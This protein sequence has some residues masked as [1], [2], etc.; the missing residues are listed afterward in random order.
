[1]PL[2]QCTVRD[3][4]S[5]GGSPVYVCLFRLR[6]SADSPT[7][8]AVLLGVIAPS[9]GLRR[10]YIQ[11]ISLHGLVRSQNIEMG[12]DADTGGQ[13]RYVIELAK[14]L[15]ATPG[16]TRVDLFTR[17]IRDKRISPDYSEEIEFISEN[18]QIVRLSCGGG[19]YHRKEKIWPFVDEYVDRMLSYTRKLGL[20]PAVVHGHYADAGYIAKEMASALG[21]PF[22]FTGHSLGKPK[23]DYLLEE[24]WTREKC[25][26]VLAID[27]RIHVE[28]ECLAAADLVIC[29]T[30]H[31]KDTGYCKYPRNEKCR[32][33]VIPPGTDLNRF[34]PYY[35]YQ[36][37]PLGISEKFKQARVHME[38][39]LQQFLF[40]PEKPV[41]V[42]LCRPD[43]RKNIQAL[44]KAYGESLPLQ[45]IS[46]LVILAGI[47]RDIEVMPDNEREVL[48]DILLM[49]DRYNLYGKMAIPKEHDSEF[50]VPELYRIAA[51]GHG[52]FA[53]TA[54]V[55]LFGLTF[56]EAAATGLPFVGTMNGGP[57][58]IVK[59]CASGL[60]VDVYDQQSLTDTL[61]TLLTDRGKW[62]ALSNNGVNHT[63][64]HYSWKSHCESYVASLKELTEAS[65]MLGSRR[66]K[67]S[68]DSRLRDVNSLII[69]DID[70]T[71]IG[72]DLALERFI[73]LLQE[74]RETLAFGVASGR[75]PELIEEILERYGIDDIDVVIAAVGTEIYYGRELRPDNSW[76]ARLRHKWFPDLIRKALS[77]FD[78][79]QLQEDNF[80]QREF[81]ISYNLTAEK[82]GPEALQEI[83][84]ALDASRSAYSLVLSHDRFIDVLPHRATKGKAVRYLSQKWNIPLEHIATGGDSGNDY[85][86]LSG[87]TSGIVVGNYSYE[88]ESLKNSTH[89][90]YFAEGHY[91][92]GLIEGLQH[93]GLVDSG[94][95]NQV[96]IS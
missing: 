56:I 44:I 25:N 64:K 21:V 82:D 9:E 23:L 8:Y 58:D 48:T 37:N 79:I 86:M 39:A 92:N 51:A 74:H 24:G 84:Q 4:S 3:R 46:N 26:D 32:I 43:R 90:V 7:I 42:A 45:S 36:I 91:A 70:N 81:K 78:W 94:S 65:D 73:E 88:L 35:E 47:R 67:Q 89:V 41:I 22:I 80:A 68:I 85:D 71:L 72:D 96:N 13:V 34:F 54:F 27:H 38:Q 69:T 95:A 10:M 15:A 14:E 31:E 18:C 40:A 57:Q 61:L 30:H 6:K 19:R 2:L 83:Q 29:S 16:V 93:Y 49:M 60:L 87:R 17:K 59:N 12:R 33:E 76:K 55:E 20:T 75:S 53:N 1:M 28:Q 52:V 66:R 62:T 77:D 50:E 63:P 11:L 5:R